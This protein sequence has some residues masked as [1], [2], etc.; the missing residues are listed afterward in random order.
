MIAPNAESRR[1]VGLIVVEPGRSRRGL[2]TDH[3]TAFGATTVLGATIE[4]LRGCEQL[5]EIVVIHAADQPPPAVRGV[6]CHASGQPL[7]DAGHRRC[8]AAR[9]WS[10]N[11]WRGGLGGATVYD[12]LLAPAAMAEA[13]DAVKADAALIVGP[14]WPLVDAALC[15]AVIDRHLESPDHHKLTFTQAPPGL[16][17][18]V[19]SRTLLE[20]VSH[21][22]VT[23]GAMLD[24]N[25]RSPQ[26]D[27]IARD[28]CVQ[29]DPSVRGA[30]LRATF[31][32]PR[33]REA[34]A[35]VAADADAAEVVRTLASRDRLPQQVTVELTPRRPS[36]GPITPQHYFHPQREPLSMDT[37]GAIFAELAAEPDTAIML[38][39]IGDALVHPRWPDMV[40][41]ARE[42]GVWGVGVETD[43][44]VEP[45]TLR[46]LVE[47]PLDAIVVRLNADEPQTYARLMGADMHTRVLDNIQ[48]LLNHRTRGLPWVVPHMIKTTDNVAEMEGFVDRWTQFCGHAVVAGPPQGAGVMPDVAVMDMA[49]PRRVA[50]RQLSHRMT[51]LSD[52]RAALCDQDWAGEHAL[53]RVGDEALSALWLRVGT[54]G[55]EHR[56]GCYHGACADCRQWHRP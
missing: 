13:L 22:G 56:A 32:A 18:C 21:N 7:D 46:A 34:M 24:Y 44:H 49:P 33:W 12:E 23:I 5:D 39:G 27:P 54:V 52:G 1:V 6:R 51:I 40:R 38:G 53:G 41:A 29:I 28:V 8:I 9:K 17:G 43:L 35:G 42:A 15:D 48:W 2:S 26:G 25:P 30:A 31:D 37:A 50:C 47:L 3:D 10:P 4:R 16:C 36:T 11:A 20:E 45:D 14:D 55:R 19:V